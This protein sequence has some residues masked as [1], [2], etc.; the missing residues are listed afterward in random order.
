MT[1][2]APATPILDSL[3]ERAKSAQR[4]IV[5][6]EAA[7]DERT[8][9]AVA[10][11]AA[12]GWAKPMLLGRREDHAT[13][14]EALGL[15]IAGARFVYPTDDPVTQRLVEHFQKRRA[16]DAMTD[17][18]VRAMLLT[19]P[20][21]Y[22]AGLVALGV[23][24]GMT[25]GAVASTA[26][27]LRAAIKMVGPRD[28]LKTIS[29]FFLMALPGNSPFGHQG[30]MIFADCAVIPDPTSEQLVDIAIAAAEG[31]REL[32]PGFEPRV[33]LLSFSTRGSADHPYV[34]KVTRAAAMLRERAPHLCCDGELQ[35]DAAL[36][37]SVAARKAKDSPLNGR[38]NVLI[39]PDLNAGNIAYKMVQRL[40]GAVALGPFLSGLA[41]PINDLSRG[42]SID[43]IAM[44]AAVTAA[45]AAG[46]T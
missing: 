39:F 32:I 8:F 31:G 44:V 37:P 26:D 12:Q 13:T 30:A 42:A 35:V 29:S 11:V 21:M 7:T 1:T 14:A 23:A 27:V 19:N 28:G 20:V 46:T 2:A 5:F 16:K 34:H 15:S 18:Q 4:T 24:D 3:F 41:A 43:D 9:R 45:R 40:A 22:G 10:R 33:A 25:A 17:A 36:V 38:A 6:P